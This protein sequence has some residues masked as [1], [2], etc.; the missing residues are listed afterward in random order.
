MNVL[1]AL[2]KCTSS[3]FLVGF[4]SKTGADLGNDILA[5]AGLIVLISA[6][7]VLFEMTNLEPATATSE[8]SLEGARAIG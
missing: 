6:V 3:A 2:I 5:L 4:L 7:F 8:G 1:S